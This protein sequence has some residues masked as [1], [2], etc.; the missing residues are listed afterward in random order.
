MDF[1][2][3]FAWAFPPTRTARYRKARRENE[4]EV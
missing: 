3:L 4:T 2:N 1:G